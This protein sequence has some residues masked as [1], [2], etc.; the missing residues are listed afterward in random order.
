MKA[1]KVDR[2]NSDSP[3]GSIDF[4][5]LGGRLAGCGYICPGCGGEDFMSLHDEQGW[6]FSGS[7]ESPSLRPSV[8]HTPCGWHGYLTNGEWVPV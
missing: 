8:L 7:E 5:Y 6:R 1:T 2:V 3:K 4:R